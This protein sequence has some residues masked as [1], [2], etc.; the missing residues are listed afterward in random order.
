LSSRTAPDQQYV[1]THKYLIGLK[2]ESKKQRNVQLEL[3]LIAIS[4]L[5]IPVLSQ[6]NNTN[7][8]IL[9]TQIIYKAMIH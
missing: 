6:D 1:R 5:C 7:I 8:N 4:E 9:L 3:S 2:L